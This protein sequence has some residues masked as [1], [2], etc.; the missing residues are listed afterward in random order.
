MWLVKMVLPYLNEFLVKLRAL[1]SGDPATTM[2]VNFRIFFTHHF[3]IFNFTF[4]Y[5]LPYCENNKKSPKYDNGSWQFCCL[6]W[7]GVGVP[8]LFGR[9]PNWVSV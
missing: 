1:F 7:Q 6:F 4:E 9:W 3:P 8:S 5:F 2:K